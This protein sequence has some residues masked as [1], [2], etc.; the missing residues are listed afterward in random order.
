M[1]KGPRL[2]LRAFTKADLPV[3]QAYSHDVEV[4]VLGGGDPPMPSTLEQWDK[5]YDSHVGKEDIKEA[6]FIMEA[7]GAAIGMCG[8]WRFDATSQT[9]MLGIT[10]GN[11]EYWSRGYGREAIGLL[12]DYAFRLR[13]VRKVH[14]TT[15][16]PNV[17]AIRCYLA[18][19]FT[20]EGRLRKHLWSDGQYVDEVHMGVLK[21]EWQASVAPK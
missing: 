5:W 8:L 6:N 4:E 21:E 15:S 1:L 12:L 19:G 2:I 18:S 13:N 9:C 16:S 11:K 3:L 17:R 20:E 10:I 7:E 14:L